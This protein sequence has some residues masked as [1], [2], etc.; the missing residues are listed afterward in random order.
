MRFTEK[1]KLLEQTR[2][3]S[4]T[5]DQLQQSCEVNVARLTDVSI[6]LSGMG[7]GKKKNSAKKFD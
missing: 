7:S 6:L 4:E 2:T 3:V 5:S 1:I